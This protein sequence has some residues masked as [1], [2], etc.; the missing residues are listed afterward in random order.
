MISRAPVWRVLARFGCTLA[1][2][3][4]VWFLARC[5]DG[6]PP[7]R[8]WDAPPTVFSAARADAALKRI[9]GPERPHPTASAENDAV[10]VRIIYEFS[11]LGIDTH[12]DR[13][14]ACN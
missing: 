10:R 4:A 11:M 8:G 7:P 1:A 6:T 9:L 14:F 3:V 2:A 5:Y 13:G 12:V